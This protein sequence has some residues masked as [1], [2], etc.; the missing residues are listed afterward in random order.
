[1]LSGLEAILFDMDGVLFHSTE[2]HARAYI[3]AF[4]EAGV[5]GPAYAELA[6]RRTDDAV[7]AVLRGQGRAHT[8]T[9]ISAIVDRKRMLA[10][11]FLRSNPP[12]IEGCSELL[13][14]L[15]QR[16]R[17]GLVSSASRKT[18]ELFLESSGCRS[19]FA[20][21]L[22]GEQFI[23]A[24]PA[25]D[26][27]LAALKNLAVAADVALVVEDSVAGVQAGRASGV[28]VVGIGSDGQADALRRA[29]ACVVLASALDLPELLHENHRS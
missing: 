15:C 14:G 13:D 25:P 8:P 2:A 27:Y 17:L 4:E 29:G 11:H 21:V 7:E 1:M 12:V 23:Q 20:I 3:Q 10:M 18:V 6:G 16:F 24:K 19:Y 5:T 22:N 26:P 9:A 28:R